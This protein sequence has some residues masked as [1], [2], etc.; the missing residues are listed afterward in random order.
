VNYHLYLA[1]YS[2]HNNKFA[3]AAATL[4]KLLNEI[5]FKDIP[6]AEA[7]VKLFLTLNLLLAEKSDQAEI[8]LRSISRKLAS[9]ELSGRFPA[10]EYFAKFLKI[11]QND[12]SSTKLK[13]LE[14]AFNAF[15]QV[16]KGK[17]AILYIVRIKEEHLQQLAH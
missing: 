14:N 16:N 4:N 3:E 9:D 15:M 1:A 2:F 5:S 13:K 6:F 7:R 8:T 10:A 12:N 17:S 11:A